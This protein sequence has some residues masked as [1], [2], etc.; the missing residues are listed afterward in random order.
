[1]L[2]MFFAM[3]QFVSFPNRKDSIVKGREADFNIEA[4]GK[5]GFYRGGQC[6]PTYPNST[7]IS[8]EHKEWCSNVAK[9][10]ESQPWITYSLK[11]KR[12]KLNGFSLRNGCCRYVDCCCTEDGHLINDGDVF[13]CCRLYSFELQGSNDNKTWKTIHQVSQK[14]DFYFC[15][16][17]TYEFPLT[18]AFQYLRIV[19][20]A[21]YPYC[22]YCMVLNE[23]DFYGEVLD[24]FIDSFY[25]NEDNEESVSIIGKVSK[26]D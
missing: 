15:K 17:E 25:E 3:V 8:D 24:G 6:H 11:G 4:S 18:E 1:M 23:V 26:S 13:C 2:F 10:G 20:T 9:V 7:L 21:P 16:F 14:K 5:L 19:Q 12:M 22:P